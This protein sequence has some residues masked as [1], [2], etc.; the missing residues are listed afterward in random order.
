MARLRGDRRAS[1]TL[2]FGIIALLL[3]A[4]SLAV[5]EVGLLFWAKNTL[6]SVAA[7]TARCAAIGSPDCTDV[8]SYAV[9]RVTNWMFAGVVTSADVVPTTVSTCNGVTGTGAFQK[10]TITTTYFAGNW[11]PSIVPDFAN[12]TLTASACYPKL[13]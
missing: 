10:V 5:I 13:S 11:L 1:T 2:E 3:V 6:Q 8:S 7:S 9:S 12:K 4:L